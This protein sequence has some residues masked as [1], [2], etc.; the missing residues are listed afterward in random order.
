MKRY[1]E[2][3]DG[4]YQ[5]LDQE[6]FDCWGRVDFETVEI[7]DFIH[8]AL[9][10]L[11]SDKLLPIPSQVQVLILG[12]GTGPVACVLSQLGYQVSGV[13]VSPKAIEMAK[14][15]AQQRNLEIQYWVADLCRESIGELK[16][17]LIIDSHCLHCIVPEVDRT[18]FLHSTHRAL[19]KGGIFLTETMI[20]QLDNDDAYS[21]ENGIVW[22]PYGTEQPEYEPRECRD[23]QWY[24]PQRLLRSSQEEMNQEITQSGF[25]VIWQGVRATRSDQDV[26]SYQGIALKK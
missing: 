6:G 13:D 1:Y 9:K 17:N 10:R 26:P 21:D 18:S 2:G 5:R 23:G 14:R 22:T 16:Y 3:H 19:K 4:V 15:Q 24:V 25:E 7:L 12:C 8:S 20:G 11:H